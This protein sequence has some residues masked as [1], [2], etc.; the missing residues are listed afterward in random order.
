[1]LNS[2]HTSWQPGTAPIAVIM[3]TLNEGHNM[4]AV[5]ENLKGWAR[6]VFIVDSYSTDDTIDIALKHGVHVVQR[7]FRGF[8]NQWNYA[9]SQ[10]PITTPWTMKL[11]PDER[12]TDEL[13]INISGE[14]LSN[15]CRGL[16]IDRRLW[17]MGRPL[18]ILQEVVRV[19]KTGSCKFTDVSVNEHPLID[20]EIL[21]V[22]GTLEHHDSPSLHHWITKQN[23]YTTAEA[24]SRFR[25]AKLAVEPRLFGTRL[26]RRMWFKKNYNRIPLRYHI[27]FIVNICYSKPWIS[28]SQ[29]IA[30][31]R[32]RVWVRRTIEYKLM[33]MH[34]TGCETKLPE[35]V[36]GD[37]HPGA[38]QSLD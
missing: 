31:A 14:L 26:E 2:D 38:I 35:S 1:M 16:S 25:N 8:G 3:I 13:K 10:L 18:P 12:L 32:L 34:T 36:L 9:I 5:L 19:W 23:L 29:G 37:P 24:L 28:G 17:F 7:R 21:H 30:W 20:G 15:R 6:E 33:E 11:D 22:E 4:E 27:Q